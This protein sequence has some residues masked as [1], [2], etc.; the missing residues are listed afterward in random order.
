MGRVVCGQDMP[1]IRSTGTSVTRALA[2]TGVES[3]S[4]LWCAELAQTGSGQRGIGWHAE[5]PVGEAR[6]ETYRARCG[7]NWKVGFNNSVRY[8]ETRRLATVEIPSWTN[9]VP[10]L[11]ADSQHTHLWQC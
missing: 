10:A 1:S 2:E 9:T 8:E 6:A 7:R 11:A 4:S 5:H 3:P